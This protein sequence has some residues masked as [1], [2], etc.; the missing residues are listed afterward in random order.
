MTHIS[1]CGLE[2]Y[3]QKAGIYWKNMQRPKVFMIFLIN[4]LKIEEKLDKYEETDC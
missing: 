1:I 4:N 3:N 2:V